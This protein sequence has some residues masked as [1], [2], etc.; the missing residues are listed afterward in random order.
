MSMSIDTTGSQGKNQANQAEKGESLRA[1]IAIILSVLFVCSTAA[2]FTAG[3]AYRLGYLYEIG[4]DLAQLP[5]DFHETSFWG[6][7]GGLP[8]AIV[9]FIATVV[10]L[11]ACGLLFWLANVLWK[12]ATKRWQRLRR[13]T[14][15]SATPRPRAETH[16][17]F[18][19]SAFLLLPVI[20]LMAIAYFGVAEFQKAGTKKGKELIEAL[21]TDAA[22][23]SAKYGTQKIELWLSSPA[24]TVVRGYRLLC[25]ESFCSI[26]DSNPEVRAI[27]LVSLAKSAKYVWSM[28]VDCD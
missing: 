20:Y 15:I 11:L 1:W 22:A 14:R 10:V 9:W 6:F 16:V 28:A 25:T 26:Y 18:I 13:L 7:S 21:R 12:L 8:L 27:R 2:L 23:A 3:H 19:L 17:R 5:E 4:Y 24:D